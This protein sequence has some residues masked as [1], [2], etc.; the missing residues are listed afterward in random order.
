MSNMLRRDRWMVSAAALV[1][2]GVASSGGMGGRAALAEE[3]AKLEEIPGSP[4]KRVV[5]TEKAAERLAI[6]TEPVREEPVARWMVVSGEVEAAKA[7]LTAPVAAAGAADGAPVLVRVP[8]PGDQAGAGGQATLVLS[9]V[10]KDQGGAGQGGQAPAV[11]GS[12]FV[13]PPG[14]DD[15]AS[16]PARPVEAAAGAKAQY[17]QVADTAGRGLAPGQDVHIRVA[18]PGSGAP[19]KVIP[20]SAVFYDAHGNVW[21]YTNP[22]PLV[23]VRQP[24][25]VEHI[26]GD[27][28]VLKEGSAVSGEVVTAG[29][30]ELWGIESEFGGGH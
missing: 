26:E 23:F 15:R 14:A 8:L 27:V 11:P 10:G 16:I 20:Y 29:A 12:A 2:A 28:A 9:I 5:L 21:A 6:A 30:T 3:P 1:I 25:D 24:V 18:Q 13:L 22:E 17:Y 19:Q 4:L 7:G